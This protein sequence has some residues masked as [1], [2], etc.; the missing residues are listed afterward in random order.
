MTER[1]R[2]IE[3]LFTEAA[4]LDPAERKRYLDERCAGDPALLRELQTLLDAGDEAEGYFGEL[5]RRAGLT[6]LSSDAAG[7]VVGAYRLLH[8]LGRGGMGS[9]YL[10]ERAD[11]QFQ[12][13]VAIKLVPIALWGAE[14]R[15]RFMQERQ[16]LA[17]L[18]HPC[19][20]RLLDGGVCNDGVPYL[21]MEYVEGQP[22]DVYCDEN[23][24]GL[25]GRLALFMKVCEA[26]A[27][28]HRNLVI[29]RDLKPGNIL[30]T[31]DGMLKLLDF[32]IAKLIGPEAIGGEDLTRLGARPLTPAYSSPELIRGEGITTASDTYALGVLLYKLLCGCLPHDLSGLN[33]MESA[34]QI[35]ET[36]PLPPS[37]VGEQAD[38][39]R[40]GVKGKERRRLTGDLDMIVMKALRKEP[41]RRYGSVEQF[42]ED[43]DRFLNDKP[44]HARPDTPGYRLSRFVRRHR[45]GVSATAALTALAITS[46]VVITTYAVRVTEQKNQIMLERNKARQEE[47]FLAHLFDAASP[48]T[49]RGKTITARDLLD[50]GA[51][52]IENEL[53]GQPPVEADMLEQVG[54]IYSRMGLYKKAEPLLRKSL[55]IRLKLYGQDSKPVEES[56]NNLAG[57]KESTGDYPAAVRLY[58]TALDALDHLPGD[59]LLP[60]STVLNNLGEM[61]ARMGKWDR[62]NDYVERALA[63]RLKR[64]GLKNGRT[65]D[66]LATLAFIK[67][68]LGDFASAEKLQKEA[69][70]NRRALYGDTHPRVAESLNDLAITLK[71]EGKLA[72]AENAYRQ[73]L[74]VKRALYGQ[75]NNSILITTYNLARLL[76]AEGKADAALATLGGILPAAKRIWGD[77]NPTL[78]IFYTGYGGMLAGAG[79]FSA[80]RRALGKS[81]SIL[82]TTLP[83]GHYRLGDLQQAMGDLAGD[84]KDYPQSVDHYR[85][86]LAIYKHAFPPGHWKI[87]QVESELGNSLRLEKQYATAKP[88]LISGFTVLRSKL[89]LANPKTQT[90]LHFLI[91][92]YRARGNQSRL[93][94]YSALLASGET[95]ETPL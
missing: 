74:K 44:V 11:L 31:R 9:V 5:A 42:E 59:Q 34:Q 57:L 41:E 79:R 55:S 51:A 54:V 67:Q 43:V 15:Q 91:D 19:I 50:R 10:A 7:R 25:E 56:L 80:A 94:H 47:D 29:H 90:A 17:R 16:I 71:A 64:L 70:E 22:L 26:V 75:V 46:G 52:R 39:A 81:D 48:E 78:G 76:Q 61:M 92:Y 27:H 77:K 87:A 89:G 18:E 14:A 49:A 28:A 69:L 32:G 21:V 6:S 95:P 40:G 33:E 88:L 37:R 72:E 20:A 2:K 62:A 24:I 1:W 8:L 4:A 68:R 3:S 23:H 86:A 58:T 30:V 82:G 73:A 13:R 38:C 65:L 93:E 36:V 60:R 35:C 66:T 84:Q 12:K 45:I 83:A 85:K 53:A 63:I